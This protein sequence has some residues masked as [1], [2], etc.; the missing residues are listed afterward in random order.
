M[1]ERFHKIKPGIKELSPEGIELGASMMGELDSGTFTYFAGA[2]AISGTPADNGLSVWELPAA[3]YII[4]SLEAENFSEL[5]TS[6]LN[7][8]MNYLFSVWLPNHK[9]RTLPFSAEKYKTTSGDVSM[10][11]WVI[12]DPVKSDN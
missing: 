6:A 8:A 3:E 4:C 2:S 10:E 11:L 5:I 12:P 7:K 9:L 1:W